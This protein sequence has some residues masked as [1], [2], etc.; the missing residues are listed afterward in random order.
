MDTGDLVARFLDCVDAHYVLAEKTGAIRA[1]IERRLAAGAYAALEPSA[2]AEA[3]TADLR[4]CSGDAHFKVVHEER[5]RPL[6]SGATEETP[7]E[8]ERFR[9]VARFHNHGCGAVRRLAGNVGYWRIEEFY[10]LVDGSGPTFVAAM[11][12]LVH[13]DAL[14]VDVRGN[15]GGD[16]ATVALAC[17]FFFDV[18][19][20]HLNT[21][22]GRGAGAG[23][24][25]SEEQWW[26]LPH[27]DCERYLGKDV[28]VLVD[29][30]TFS[31]AEELAYDLQSL[32]RATLVGRRTA[33]AAHLRDSFQIDAHFS[34]PHPDEA[35]RQPE[36]G[37]QLG[38]P[39]RGPRRGGGARRRVRRG[40]RPGAAARSP[41]GRAPPRRSGGRSERPSWSWTRTRSSD[42]LG[43]ERRVRAWGRPAERP[44]QP[45][46][47]CPVRAP[48]SMTAAFPLRLSTL[49]PRRVRIGRVWLGDRDRRGGERWGTAVGRP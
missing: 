49:V 27:L 35:A 2:V 43:K 10:D 8:V 28:Y 25:V 20:V 47:D 14:L 4:E 39:R 41:K 45:G 18:E 12:L 23:G 21:V 46:V 16:P 40:L 38:A 17:S 37:R 33:G 36:D 24:G 13:T 11:R 3:V 1:A 31:A 30:R 34:I 5:A 22:Q 26:T 32:G 48:R 44:L 9:R 15:T 29:E 42:G 7:E 6:R 19:P